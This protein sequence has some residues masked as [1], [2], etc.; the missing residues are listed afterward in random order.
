MEIDI[1][2]LLEHLELVRFCPVSEVPGDIP[3]PMADL[4]RSLRLREQIS[5]PGLPG[6][7]EARQEYQ[8]KAHEAW[9]ARQQRL[10]DFVQYHGAQM[11]SSAAQ[12]LPFRGPRMRGCRDTAESLKQIS[13]EPC[14]PWSNEIFLFTYW[15]VAVLAYGEEDTLQAILD[16]LTKGMTACALLDQLETGRGNRDAETIA[17]SF[18][19]APV[20]LCTDN[21]AVHF[22]T[23]LLVHPYH[24][25]PHGMS[26]RTTSVC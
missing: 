3:K 11:R 4:F 23:E 17:V 14:K 13:P 24:C 7:P 2:V 22:L 10:S 21:P 15:A 16:L 5:A 9:K 26:R 25:A 1:D 8:L 19:L 12:V 20:L 18:T 6:A